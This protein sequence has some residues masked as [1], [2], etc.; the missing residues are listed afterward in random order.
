MCRGPPA[1]L[2]GANVKLIIGCDHGGWELARHLATWLEAAGHTVKAIGATDGESTDYP[3]VAQ[4]VAQAVASGEYERGI[5][6]CGS[7]I[8]VSIAANK[9]PGIRCA[10]CHDELTARLSRQHNDSN[11]LALGGRLV[12]PTLAE[13]IVKTW[14]ETPFEGGR[15]ARRIGQIAEIE[16]S[17]A[18]A[19]A[20][21]QEKERDHEPSSP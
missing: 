18:A 16:Q 21:A 5:L 6:V 19:P 12:G 10:L 13:A 17:S 8:G 11:V 1:D 15:H 3:P 7:G 14:L 20:A 9:V 4:T 2:G